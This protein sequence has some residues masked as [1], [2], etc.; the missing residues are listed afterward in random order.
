MTTIVLAMERRKMDNML[1]YISVH[2]LQ[3]HEYGKGL[4]VYGKPYII[5]Y[6]TYLLIQCDVFNSIV[7]P[8]E[9]L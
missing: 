3:L 8:N 6:G 7:P 1:V 4:L 2:R 5:C 9:C